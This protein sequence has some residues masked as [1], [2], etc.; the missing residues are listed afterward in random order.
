MSAKATIC[1]FCGWV[2][3]GRLYGPGPGSLRGG[4]ASVT[5]FL[6]VVSLAEPHSRECA[7]YVQRQIG[8]HS[9]KLNYGA[10][11]DR[12]RQLF[13]LLREERSDG[14]E[15]FVGNLYERLS[16]IF[17]SGFVFGDG[18]FV[19]LRFVVLDEAAHAFEIPAWGIVVFVFHLPLLRMRLR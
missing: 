18:F 5:A 9:V 14:R 12:D 19:S 3:R 6:L 1:R 16:L 2:W 13:G 17:E 4:F 8:P 15:Q 11:V 10:S 7:I